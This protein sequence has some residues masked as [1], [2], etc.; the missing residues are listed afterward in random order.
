M[1]RIQEGPQ[2]FFRLGP[3]DPAKAPCFGLLRGD[4]VARIDANYWRLT[5][6][7]RERFAKPLFPIES[8][9]QSLTVVQYGSSALAS[10]APIGV[11]IV[12]MNNLQ[13]DGWDLSDL[14]YI[15]LTDQE[16]DNY[17]LERGD[18]LFNRTNSKELVGKCAVFNETGV[19]VFASYLIRVRTDPARLLPRFASDFLGTSAGRV[20]ID[21]LSRQIIGMT[22]INAEEIRELSIPIPE[23]DRQKMFVAAMDSAREERRKKLNEAAASLAEIEGFILGTLGLPV[24]PR[25]KIVFA[26]PFSQLQPA[27][28]PDRYRG[29]QLEK[30]LPFSATIGDVAELIDGRVTPQSDGPNDSWDWIRID[31]LPS[32]PLQIESVR[33]GQGKDIP[34]TFFEVQEN[35]ILLARLGP[36][37]QNAKFVLCPKLSRRTVAAAYPLWSGDATCCVWRF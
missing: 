26:I 3:V 12:R 27:F 9:G 5:P 30:A 25:P 7:V 37:I 13:D 15:E 31:D 14:K 11:P 1:A 4:I 17:R 21:R 29:M 34:G 32:Q 10:A 36:T 2:A 24:L 20:Q 35:D 22:N 33:T 23:L 19:W 16:I 6:V 8:L 28:N 18:I